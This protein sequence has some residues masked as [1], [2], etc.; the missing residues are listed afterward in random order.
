ML[1]SAS[2]TWA[3]SW[4]DRPVLAALGSGLLFYEARTSRSLYERANGYNYDAVKIFMP[5]GSK[6]PVVTGAT[7]KTSITFFEN[8]SSAIVRWG[9]LGFLGSIPFDMDK[10]AYERDRDARPEWPA[11][12]QFGQVRA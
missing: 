7:C 12:S 1:R 9:R 10:W 3:D 6:Q 8:I 11:R 5:A 4:E 2:A